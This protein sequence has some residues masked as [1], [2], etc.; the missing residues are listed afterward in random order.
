MTYHTLLFISHGSPQYTASSDTSYMFCSTICFLRNE[1]GRDPRV[2]T[3][4][5]SFTA[6]DGFILHLFSSRVYFERCVTV[7]FRLVAYVRTA[8]R[9]NL[10]YALQKQG[11]ASCQKLLNHKFHGKGPEPRL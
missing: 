3:P 2:G 8:A 1:S 4:L 11:T 7:C 10:V 5:E 6:S 9:T